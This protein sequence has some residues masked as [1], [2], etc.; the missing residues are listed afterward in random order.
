MP[1]EIPG[2]PHRFW[3][4][5]YKGSEACYTPTE[6]EILAAYEG[7]QAASEVIG[8]EAQLYLAPDLP[9]LGWM[10]KGKV[11]FT[12]HATDAVWSK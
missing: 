5:R 2:L 9:M 10:F 11:P 1:R 4:W 12:H 8:S 3:S 7:V 6:K